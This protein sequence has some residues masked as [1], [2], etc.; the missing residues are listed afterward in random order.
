MSNRRSRVRSSMYVKTCSTRPQCTLA[1]V[2]FVGVEPSR[3][4]DGTPHRWRRMCVRVSTKP[5][6]TQRW[7]AQAHTRVKSSE[8][9]KIGSNRP[10]STRAVVTCFGVKSSSNMIGTT[11]RLF[12]CLNISYPTPFN[13]SLSITRTRSRDNLTDGEH[14]T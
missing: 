1:F 12:Y 9:V 4:I 13:S 8:L 6:A 5:H 10:R 2:S 3:N 11:H 14:Q 7:M